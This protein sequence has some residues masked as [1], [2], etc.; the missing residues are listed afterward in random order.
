MQTKIKFKDLAF[1]D[2][3]PLWFAFETRL[4]DMMLAMVEPL[5]RKGL[6]DTTF[7]AQVM[8]A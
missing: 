4:R 2:D 5:I 6:L 1:Y 8:K 3:N 7:V